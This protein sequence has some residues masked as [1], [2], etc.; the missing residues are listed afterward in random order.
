MKSD[1]VT[2]D[3]SYSL[4]LSIPFTHQTKCSFQ[5]PLMMLTSRD[6]CCSVVTNLWLVLFLVLFC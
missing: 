5:S 2:N 3:L 6:T 1:V 4:Q